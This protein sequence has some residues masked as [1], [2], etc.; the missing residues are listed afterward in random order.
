MSMRILFSDEKRFDVNGFYNKQDDRI[1]SLNRLEADISEETLR[2]IK[3]P[4]GVMIWFV[5]IRKRRRTC[6]TS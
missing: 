5:Q 2:T 6:P 3:F 1:R 4:P